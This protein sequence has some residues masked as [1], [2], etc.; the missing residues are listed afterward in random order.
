MSRYSFLGELPDCSSAEFV[1]LT[2]KANAEAI[3][4][5]LAAVSE[6]HVPPGLDRK[7]LC[8]D[9]A[10][11][12]HSR[13]AAV[14][15]FDGAKAQAQLRLL[16]RIRKTAEKLASLLKKADVSLDA[17]I[18]FCLEE[19]TPASEKIAPP[20][21]S[22]I[23]PKPIDQLNGLLRAI[24]MTEGERERV[25]MKWRKAHKRA[26]D[27]RGRRVTEKEW[28]AGVSLPLVFEMHFPQRAGRSRD[29]AGRPSGPMISFI[30]ATM[31][32][33]GLRYSPESIAKA[34]SL[35]APLALREIE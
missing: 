4:R 12:Y 26:R 16:G 20:M 19:I 35:R 9:I 34:Y 17:R 5:I 7:A 29:E 2:K 33:L 24:A 31:Q 18:T 8:A 23:T 3:D 11:A 1:K 14:D 6:K 10:D 28:L 22:P 27:L 25:A 30:A 15:L 32:E 21:G 13:H